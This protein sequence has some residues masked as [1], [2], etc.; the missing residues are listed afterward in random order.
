M[1]A[2]DHERDED[3]FPG[4]RSEC[5]VTAHESSPD[6]L[7]FTEKGNTDGWIATDYAVELSR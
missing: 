1:E 7:V 3:A 4:D 6:R 5:H 2:T